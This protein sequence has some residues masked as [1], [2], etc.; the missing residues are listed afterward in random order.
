MCQQSLLQLPLLPD[1][2]LHKGIACARMRIVMGLFLSSLFLSSSFAL[3]VSLQTL[4]YGNFA[5]CCLAVLC[6]HVAR[7]VA[8]IS[9]CARSLATF[10]PPS[11]LHSPIDSPCSSSAARLWCDR[12]SGCLHLLVQREGALLSIS[13]VSRAAHTLLALLL[14]V[15]LSGRPCA[16]VDMEN[17][18]LAE[19]LVLY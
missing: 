18:G 4:C 16:P 7:V 15:R 2:Q 1:A 14:S 8:Y 19:R 11:F 6:E 12:L 3:S 10:L 17:C 9:P 5:R 13:P